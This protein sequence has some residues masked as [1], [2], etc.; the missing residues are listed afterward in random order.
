MPTH[1]SANLDLSVHP[2][3]EAG[4]PNRHLVTISKDQSPAVSAGGTQA[5]CSPSCLLPGTPQMRGY[6]LTAS[7]GVL[8]S[9]AE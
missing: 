6:H 2:D 8:P 9:S 3:P 5:A 4:S 1:T 7:Q